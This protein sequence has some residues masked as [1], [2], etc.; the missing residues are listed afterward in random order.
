MIF[1]E[2][3]RSVG[4]VAILAC[5]ATTAGAQTRS[6]LRFADD[7]AATAREARERRI[8]IMIA[9][10]QASCPYCLTAKREYL[11]PMQNSIGLRDKVIIR[12]IDIDSGAELRDFEG[13][14][15]TQDEF[16]KRYQV[17]RV[18]TVIVM[19]DKGK[20][21]ASPI[22]GLMAAD[23]YGLYLEKAI[24]EGLYRMRRPN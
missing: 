8:P 19:D 9:F 16:S 2:F 21:L 3:V 20:P 17:K 13:Q 11:I 4:I 12:E 18:P 22:V 15:L 14:A 1:K 7:L 10:T 6:E 24:E 5:A 23:F